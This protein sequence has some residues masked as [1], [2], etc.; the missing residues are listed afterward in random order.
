[1]SDFDVLNRIHLL[2]LYGPIKIWCTKRGKPK[3]SHCYHGPIIY[4]KSIQKLE[5]LCKVNIAKLHCTAR[6]KV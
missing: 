3:R 6:D 4:N 2:C 5:F 1:M